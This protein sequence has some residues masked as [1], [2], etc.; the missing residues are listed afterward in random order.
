ML[1]NYAIFVSVNI[2]TKTVIFKHVLDVV[3]TDIFLENVPIKNKD[4]K[5]VGRMVTKKNIVAFYY[6]ITAKITRRKV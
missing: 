6:L 5:D 4:V 1:N 3:K 2:L